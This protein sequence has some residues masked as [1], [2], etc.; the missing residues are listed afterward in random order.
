MNSEKCCVTN[1]NG[2]KQVWFPKKHLEKKFFFI[3]QTLAQMKS[4]VVLTAK[5]NVFKNE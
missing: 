2:I 5:Q 3:N 4:N 1:E